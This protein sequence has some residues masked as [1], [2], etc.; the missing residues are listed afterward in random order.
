MSTFTTTARSA[1]AG[2]LLA[3]ALATPAGAQGSTAND[4]GCPAQPL[5]QAFLPWADPAWY[6]SVPGGTFEA[7]GAPWTLQGGADTG[8]G[9]E[10]YFVNGRN[11]QAGLSLPS[12]GS[13]ISA[14]T[15]IGLG[16]PTL[17]FFVRNAGAP[18]GQLAI[19]ARFR[20]YSGASRSLP[21][22]V[23]TGRRAW[24][25]APPLPVWANAF[26]ALAAQDVTFTFV[27]RDGGGRWSV[28]DVYVDPYGKG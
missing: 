18:D 10:S 16:H 17:R 24:A 21:V 25:P 4:R 14:R 8:A 26:S 1:A 5:V 28:D 22:G 11:D 15:C 12:G 23:V 3:L 13:A 19:V 9:N 7:G 6:A 2:A 27:P 20:D